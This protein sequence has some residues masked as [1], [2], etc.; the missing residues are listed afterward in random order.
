MIYLLI[1]DSSVYFL[2]GIRKFSERCEKTYI[3]F[4]RLFQAVLSIWYQQVTCPTV[5]DAASLG[6]LERFQDA[7]PQSTT[8]ARIRKE[9]PWKGGDS[10]KPRYAT[11]PTQWWW[12]LSENGRWMRRR[13]KTRST[14]GGT[15]HPAFTGGSCLFGHSPR[16]TAAPPGWRFFQTVKVP[17]F[18][19]SAI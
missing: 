9:K 12:S 13:D 1:S 8:V 14:F 5:R 7:H 11:R 2:P 16:G 6:V 4:I 15:Q 17:I 19:Q 10:K 18:D 3:Q